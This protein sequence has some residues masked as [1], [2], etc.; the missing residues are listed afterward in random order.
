MRNY[1]LLKQIYDRCPDMVRRT[2]TTDQL[3]D[4]A[5]DIKDMIARER[6]EIAKAHPSYNKKQQQLKL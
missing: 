6:P 4:R 5:Q 1:E 2:Y 3:F